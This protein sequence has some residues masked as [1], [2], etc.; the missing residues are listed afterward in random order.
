MKLRHLAAATAVSVVAGCSFMGHGHGGATSAHATANGISYGERVDRRYVRPKV[1]DGALI[2]P[3]FDHNFGSACFDT[4][5]C[6]VQYKNRYDTKEDEPTEP[7]TEAARGNLSGRWLLDDLPSV[8][9]VIW[10]SKDGVSHDESIDIGAIF[11]SRL[12]RYAGDMDVTEVN[13]DVPPASPDIILVVEN[14]SIHVYMK[15]HISLLDPVDP[16]N[17]LTNFR[18]DLVIAYTQE[19]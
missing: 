3:F 2:M 5:K 19:F 11:R 12:I 1:K 7:L 4:L 6:R 8:A 18:E 16:N 13:L 9:R 10:E 14:R 15:A 17:R